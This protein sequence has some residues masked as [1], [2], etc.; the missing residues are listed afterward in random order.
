MRRA[1]RL[2]ATSPSFWPPMA[3]PYAG[4]CSMRHS[5]P[6]RSAAPPAKPCRRGASTSC[7]CSR[8]APPPHPARQA[9]PVAPAPAPR[10]AGGAAIFLAGLVGAAIAAVAVLAILR[11]APESLGLAPPS[12]T[13]SNVGAAGDIGQRLND[14]SARLAEL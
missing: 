12:G 4:A 8:R 11:F 7:C 10:R 9:N 1:A 14:V 5:P 13:E 6:A 2:P 3:S